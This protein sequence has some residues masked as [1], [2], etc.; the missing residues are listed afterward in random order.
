M[1][2]QF[3]LRTE[4][5]RYTTVDNSDN[6]NFFDYMPSPGN[7]SVDN[8]NSHIQLHILMNTKTVREIV[9]ILASLGNLPVILNTIINRV[10]S[11]MDEPVKYF[12]MS[13][14]H[15]A[16]STGKSELI[17][18]LNNFGGRF[19]VE[20][21]YGYTPFLFVCSNSTNVE[22]I[23]FCIKN[24]ANVKIPYPN[25]TYPIICPKKK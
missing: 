16:C 7:F 15:V 6:G 4:L 11:K 18:T 1:S 17:K 21:F 10:I 25:G 12:S 13:P 5:G 2:E 22:L 19:N 20:N 23:K 8:A 14:F 24:G 3:I 9:N